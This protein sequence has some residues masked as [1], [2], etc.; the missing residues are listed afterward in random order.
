MRSFLR[1]SALAASL[2]ALVAGVPGCGSDTESHA[3]KPD[4][5]AMG[6]MDTGKMDTGKMDSGKMD[7]GKVD[8]GKMEGE[9]K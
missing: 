5:G 3:G 6:T 2:G 9:K 1:A 4:G 7:S 8:S